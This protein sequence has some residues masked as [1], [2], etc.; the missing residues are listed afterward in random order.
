MDPDLLK[1]IINGALVLLWYLL[2]QKDS[3][4]AKQIELLFKKHDLDSEELQ[5]LKLQIASQHYVKGELDAK[6]D[7]LEATFADGFKDLGE[8]FDRLSMAL[9]ENAKGRGGQ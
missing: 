6:F 9:V 3:Q 2:Q 8:K 5:K 4:Q 7:K 1:W